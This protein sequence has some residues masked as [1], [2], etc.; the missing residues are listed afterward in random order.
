MKIGKSPGTDNICIELLKTDVITA[1]NVFTEL[2]SD[3]WT[4]NEIPRDWN[5]G[6]II[7]IPKKGDLQNCDNWRGITLLSMPSKIFC[8]VLL[9]RIEGDID[10]NQRQEQA[11][12]RRSKGCMDQIFSLRNIIEQ[13]TE[14]NAPLCI[15]FIDFNKAFDSIHH[16]TLWKIL[17]H[18][19]LPQKIVG[20]ISVLYKSFECSVLMDSTQTD[21]FPVKSGVRQGCILSPILFNIT[22]D[23]IMRQTTQNARHG[24]QW[25]MF[26]QLEDLDYIDDIALL[27]TNARHL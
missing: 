26:S 19:G 18:Y 4:T 17:R 14:W 9:N 11:G 5:K 10:V 21:Y 27:L 22:L 2:F 7:K 6:L 25:N 1:G 24:I 13:S 23:Y 8:R 16:E 15:G 3:I 12:F 20:L